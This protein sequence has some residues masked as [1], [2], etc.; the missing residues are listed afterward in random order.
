MNA[1]VIYVQTLIVVGSTEHEAPIE[2]IKILHRIPRI[3]YAAPTNFT[4]DAAILQQD[5]PCSTCDRT[6]SICEEIQNTNDAR[7]TTFSRAKDFGMA[8]GDLSRSRM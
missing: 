6:D 4:K 8:P 1:Q 2:H 3:T 7:K 5:P